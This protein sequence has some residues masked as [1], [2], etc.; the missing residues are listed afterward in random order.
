MTIN[1]IY[2]DTFSFPK[3]KG[4]FIENFLATPSVPSSP[5]LHSAGVEGEDPSEWEVG[6]R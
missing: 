6:G 3:G 5:T 4:L 1:K 2:N